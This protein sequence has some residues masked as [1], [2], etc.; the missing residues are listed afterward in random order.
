MK[1][2]LTENRLEN[3]ILLYIK[4]YYGELKDEVNVDKT[5]VDFIDIDGTLQ[6][7]GTKS[8]TLYVQHDFYRTCYELFGFDLSRD[9][10]KLDKVFLKLIK[11][12]FGLIFIKVLVFF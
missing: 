6:M 12:E 3:L 7:F 1:Y 8:G 2:I 10:E 5:Q 4:N 11:D 9:E